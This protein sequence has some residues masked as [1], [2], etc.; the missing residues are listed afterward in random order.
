MTTGRSILI[1]TL[2]V[3]RLNASTQRHRPVEWIQKQDP[4]IYTIYKRLWCYSATIVPGTTRDRSLSWWRIPLQYR[5]PWFDSWVRKIPWRRDRLPSPVFLGFPGGSAG[6]ESAHSTGDLGSIYG[7]GKATHSSILAW[8]ISWTEKSHTWLSDWTE[9]IKKKE[10]M[11]SKAT[12]MDLE[13]IRVSE[14]SE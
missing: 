13:I 6:K 14:K 9:L 12:W 10:I 2:N 3:N 11:P 8:R 7:L 4:H 1:I 5:R